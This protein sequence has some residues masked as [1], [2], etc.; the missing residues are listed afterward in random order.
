VQDNWPVHH[1]PDLLAALEPQE[2]PWA[3][4]LLPRGPTRASAAAEQRWGGLRLP[5]QRVWLPT[6]ASWLNPIAKRWRTLR[7]EV[8]HLHPWAD[9]LDQLRQAVARFCA[10][11]AQG[12]PALKRDVGLAIAE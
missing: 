8:T 2:S 11:F 1:H 3:L 4:P 5:I 10:G 9:A 6:S 12:S 7:Q